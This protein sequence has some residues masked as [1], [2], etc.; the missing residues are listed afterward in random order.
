MSLVERIRKM[1]LSLDEIIPKFQGRLELVR[2]DLK[3]LITGID[4]LK[5]LI[6]DNRRKSNDYTREISD[7]SNDLQ[8][9][10]NEITEI[11]KEISRSQDMANTVNMETQELNSELMAERNRLGTLEGEKNALEHS[12]SE[13][14]REKSGLQEIHDQFKPKFE[15]EVGLINERYASLKKKHDSLGYRFQAMRILCSEGYL[16]TP[17][18]NIV[19]YLAMKPSSTSSVTEIKSTLG[20]DPTALSTVLHGLATRQV[21]K[22]DESS[23]NV[24]ILAKIDLFDEVK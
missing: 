11:E 22:L 4:D 24:T 14:E 10:R 21:L 5:T 2:K 9:F 15:K 20:V 12:L 3:D 16:A 1:E 7:L 13:L 19:R 6:A 17:E 23:G 8:A 18:V